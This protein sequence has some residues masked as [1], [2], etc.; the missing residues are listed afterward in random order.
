MNDEITLGYLVDPFEQFQDT[1]GL[2]I[3][4]GTVEVYD[5]DTENLA[6]IYKDFNQT[7]QENPCPLDTLGNATIISDGTKFYNIIVKD[8]DGNILLSK[9]HI[10]V[11]DSISETV[12]I[13]QRAVVLPGDGITVVST[14]VGNTTNYT[15]AIDP[16]ITV[17]SISG[18]DGIEVS[19]DGNNYTIYPTSALFDKIDGEFGVYKKV[20]D[21]GGGNYK[22][23]IGLNHQGMCDMNND[24]IAVGYATSANNMSFAH[25]SL[26]IAAATGSHAEGYQTYIPESAVGAHAEGYTTSA[27]GLFSH[28]EGFQTLTN[29]LYSHAEGNA[30]IA[31]GDYSHAEGAT[32][33]TQGSFSHAEGIDTSAI[34]QESHAE[35]DNTVAFGVYSHSEG[36]SGI[37][38][39]Q[40]S[41]SE[42]N[43]NS[44]L[45]NYSHAEGW[46]T[47]AN[48][49]GGHTEGVDTSAFGWSN[50]AEGELCIVSGNDAHAEGF[51]T[52]AIQTAS[53]SEGYQ[54]LASGQYS[55]AEG[56]NTTTRDYG[57][58]SQGIY[59]SAIGQGSFAGGHDS[60]ASANY[61]VALGE[62]VIA[63]GVN[64]TVLGQY[65]SANASDI[66][67]I[68]NGSANDARHNI[69]AVSGTTITCAPTNLYIP[70][71]NTQLHD[72]PLD[73]ISILMNTGTE[74][75]HKSQT[76]QS[77]SYNTWKNLVTNAD[78]M[79]IP[80]DT[81][82]VRIT[83]A[84]YVEVNGSVD[85]INTIRLQIYRD[86]STTI[87]WEGYGSCASILNETGVIVFPVDLTLR[88]IGGGINGTVDQNGL[89]ISCRYN[90][91]NADLGSTNTITYDL[92]YSRII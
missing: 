21:L 51:D 60:I 18:Q 64:Q 9:N 78:T 76:R 58:H 69:F 8:G 40:G 12:I 15:V 23:N 92:H 70:R 57:A 3:V 22:V 4:N 82:V 89:R 75:F 73:I 10:K 83:G 11:A 90:D 66:F 13:N 26:T 42:G 17:S 29:N 24:S 68:G 71:N 28:T 20:T 2:P 79:T 50:H 37:A 48:S 88:S 49:Y 55:H 91:Q 52:S 77:I 6:V 72:K 31:S 39:G 53:H 5:E 16:D 61:S 38:S 7:L 44:A 1:N 81:R 32:T 67:Q 19:A 30:T 56:M 14:E 87:I 34:G 46:N 25:G 43:N 35:G 62:N 80:D 41:H 59:T 86:A 85:P 65:N 84:I 74:F 33:Y 47:F 63:N 27:G 54:T 36:Y 45:N